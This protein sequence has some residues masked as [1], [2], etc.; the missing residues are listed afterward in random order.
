MAKA[1]WGQTTVYVYDAFGQLAAEYGGAGTDSGTHYLTA[2]M[3]GS[4]RLET[5]GTAQT[6]P[7]VVRNY[8]YLPF[9][10]EIGSGT[11]GRDATFSA[12][13]YPS[14][15][16][17][18]SIRFTQKPRDA[19]TGLDYFGARYFSAAQGR[20]TSR[21]PAGFSKGHIANPQK[22]NKYAYVLNN[23]LIMVDP[24]GEAEYYVFRPLVDNT[25]A[26][27]TAIQNYTNRPGSPD[28]M[29]IY[30]KPDATAANYNAALQTE[31]ANVIFAGHTVE[32][33]GDARI[34]AGSVLLTGN[35]G[36][37][38]ATPDQGTQVAV[39]GVKAATVAVFGCNSADLSSQY[40]GT[41]FT[42]TSPT[43][44]TR[45]EDA[46]AAS[47]A[48]SMARGGTVGQATTAAQKS[49][50]NVT[51][52]VNAVPANQNQQYAKAA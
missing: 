50:V 13:Y 32:Y 18:P 44:N 36:V 38:I 31:G 27:W 3:L 30:N 39:P 34:T 8:D 23:P 15:A 25:S 9:G 52:Q 14:A 26:A 51:N 41:T 7:I 5:S 20:F 2:D 4:T 40:A 49:M 28:H 35:V 10:Q 16:M 47:Y 6:G 33:A 21:D 12:G 45:A 19:E 48:D 22:W 24:N 1:A 42:G 43:T 46:G 17:G 37:G 11:A 29:T